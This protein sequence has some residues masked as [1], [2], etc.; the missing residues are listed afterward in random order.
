VQI[1][2]HIVASLAQNQIRL[3]HPASPRFGVTRP[4]HFLVFHHPSGFVC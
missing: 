1:G 4:D 3:F 2:G